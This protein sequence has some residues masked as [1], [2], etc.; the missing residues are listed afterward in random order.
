LAFPQEGRTTFEWCSAFRTLW[1]PVF[2]ETRCFRLQPEG[3]LSKKSPTLEDVFKMLVELVNGLQRQDLQIARLES[4]IDGEHDGNSHPVTRA[5][6][7]T[8]DEVGKLC[9]RIE[10]LQEQGLV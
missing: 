5:E 1:N 4:K 6:I 2:P 9:D 7:R 8:R 3:R 10:K